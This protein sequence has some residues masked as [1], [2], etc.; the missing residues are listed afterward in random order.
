[1]NSA[2]PRR[3]FYVLKSRV[4]H[5]ILRTP[6][7]RTARPAAPA[8]TDRHPERPQRSPQDFT[9]RPATDRPQRAIPDRPQRFP[10]DRAQRS[11]PD[12]PHRRTKALA[13]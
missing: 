7:F 10:A 5:A 4:Y 11:A 13:G 2:T 8:A 3:A 9:Q 12:R 1:M 6:R